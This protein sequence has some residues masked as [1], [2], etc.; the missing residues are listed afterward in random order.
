MNDCRSLERTGMKIMGAPKRVPLA[1]SS[2]ITPT[3]RS[4][5]KTTV[6]TAKAPT[7]ESFIISS[8][9]SLSLREKYASEESM[10]PSR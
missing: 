2:E 4:M 8:F 9:R 7:L 6:S 1:K 5:T 3:L 10:R